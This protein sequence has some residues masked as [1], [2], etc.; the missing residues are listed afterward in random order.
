MFLVFKYFTKNISSL[1]DVRRS[2]NFFSLILLTI[3]SLEEW[4][5][6]KKRKRNIFQKKGSKKEM[7]F[8]TCLKQ[9][10]RN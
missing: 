10:S 6:T 7:R 5:Q 4:I 1:V 9:P 3:Q 2:P 8:K